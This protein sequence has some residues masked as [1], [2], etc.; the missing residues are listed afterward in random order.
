MLGVGP[1]GYSR[2]PFD[3]CGISR[4]DYDLHDQVAYAPPPTLVEGETVHHAARLRFHN[5]LSHLPATHRT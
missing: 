2:Y 3:N 4:V 5:Y 1:A